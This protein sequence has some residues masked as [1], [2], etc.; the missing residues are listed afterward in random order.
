MGDITNNDG[1]GHYSHYEDNRYIK[2]EL[3]PRVSFCEAGLVALAS[4]GKD[5]N[6]S[7]FFITFDDS[8]FLNDK[9][10]II[11]NV[12]SGYEIA[13]KILHFCGTK[14]GVPKCDVKISDTGIYKYNEYT[15][16]KRLKF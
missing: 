8:P 15:R 7:Q 3:S 10:T 6:G 5:T 2:D 1:T 13:K 16:D 11:G 9:Y 4:K 12:I 14:E